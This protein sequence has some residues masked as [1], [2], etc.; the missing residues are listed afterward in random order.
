MAEDRE[1]QTQMPEDLPFLFVDVE[2]AALTLRQLVM[3]ALKYST[4]RSPITIRA[5]S[6]SDRVIIS[7]R[8]EGPGI[9]EKHLKRIFEKFYRVGDRIDSVPGTGLG[10]HIAREIVS[11]HGGEIWVESTAAEGSQFS[12]S[13]PALTDKMTDHVEKVLL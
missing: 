5:R 7:V 3:N 4:P 8:D 9:P 2:L 11:A 12:F 1:I 13:L 6:D 10:L